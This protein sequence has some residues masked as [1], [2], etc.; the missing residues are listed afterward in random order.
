MEDQKVKAKEYLAV[1]KLINKEI[2]GPLKASEA[3]YRMLAKHSYCGT[4]YRAQDTSCLCYVDGSESEL[5]D[6]EEEG[7]GG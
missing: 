7:N 6:S 3:T 5:S 1:L 2:L 4:C